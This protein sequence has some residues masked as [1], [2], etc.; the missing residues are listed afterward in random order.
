MTPCLPLMIGDDLS[1]RYDVFDLDGSDFGAI[2]PDIGPFLV[3]RTDLASCLFAVNGVPGCVVRCEHLLARGVDH[4]HRQRAQP[5]Q[6]GAHPG[7]VAVG[8]L[9]SSVPGLNRR[10]VVSMVCDRVYTLTYVRGK[11]FQHKPTRQTL[12]LTRIPANFCWFKFC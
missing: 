9:H 12:S 10:T 11:M 2:L 1:A 6:E 7:A 3:E 5:S 4:L 8:A